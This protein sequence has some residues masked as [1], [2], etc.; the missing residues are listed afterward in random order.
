MRKWRYILGEIKT[1]GIIGAGKLGEALIQGF[2]NAHIERSKICVF[3]IDPDRVKYISE[4]YN[5]R[6]LDSIGTLVKESDLIIIS[7]KP[8]DVKSVAKEIGKVITPEKI[9]LTFAAATPIKY[10]SRFLPKNVPIVRG[11]P[12][13]AVSVREGMT[14]ISYSKSCSDEHVQAVVKVLSLLGKVVQVDERYLNVVTALSGSGPAYVAL[15]IDSLADAGVRFGLSKSISL[16][17][18]TQTVL[19]S[20]K[21]LLESNQHPALLRDMVATPA[22]TTIEALLKLER[23]GFRAMLVDAITA[24][25]EKAEQLERLNLSNKGDEDR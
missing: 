3:E 14:A 18:A 6:C 12:N 16:L 4:K 21:M 1:I 5:V 15:I 8:I 7:V 25:T 13:L 19:G 10:I 24:A 20:A 17:M 11:M 22:G 2:L 23:G 9:V